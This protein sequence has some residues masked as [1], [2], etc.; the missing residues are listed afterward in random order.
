VRFY[1]AILLVIALALPQLAQAQKPSRDRITRD[2]I[3]HSA[4]K[5]AD[6]Y[7]VIRA[8]RP[9]FLEVPKG[10][11]SFGYSET[12]AV[13]VFIEKRQETGVEALK[14]VVPSTVEEVRYLSPSQS[15]NEYGNRANSGAVVVKLRKD[16]GREKK[17]STTK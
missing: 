9:H 15:T 2:E 12:A 3:D 5:D 8:L 11:R 1:R 6:L 4:Q 16:V 7:Q 14:L 10:V 13:A 17:D